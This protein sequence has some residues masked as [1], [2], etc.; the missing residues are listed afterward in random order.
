[1][2]QLLNSN[3][4]SILNVSGNIANTGNLAVTQNTVT[5]NLS[6]TTLA[7]LTTVNV[8]SNIANTG[9]L[10][11][12]QNT[13]TGNL[14]VTTLANLAAVNVSGTLTA[15]ASV[16][17]N[18]ETRVSSLLTANMTAN[19]QTTL[20][21]TSTNVLSVTF[22]ETGLYEIWGFIAFGGNIKTT[23]VANLGMNV[24]FAGSATIGSIKYTAQGRANGVT[25]M[26][27]LVTTGAQTAI[28]P[29]TAGS[30]ANS[31]NNTDYLILAGVIR[32]SAIGNVNLQFGAANTTNAN[33]NLC[34][35]CT[36]VYTK[37]G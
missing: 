33:L 18:T 6:V 21:M 1:M 25:V 14:S 8:S 36:I 7:N 2:A 22:N 5:G 30:I 17:T 19:V 35:N 12:T 3:I 29:N 13:V 23:N 26:P 4:V 31:T 32:I 10:A 15:P 11:V 24:G 34:S 28:I 16:P 27:N 37:L 20:T 9:N